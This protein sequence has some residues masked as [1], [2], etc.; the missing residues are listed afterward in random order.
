MTI[1][2]NR[3]LIILL[4]SNVFISAYSQKIVFDKVDANGER[5]VETSMKS[6]SHWTSTFSIK[7]GMEAKEKQGETKYRL[8]AEFKCKDKIRID[9]YMRMLIKTNSGTVMEIKCSQEGRDATGEVYDPVSMLREYTVKVYYDISDEQIANIKNEGLA[10]VRAEMYDRD[11]NEKYTENRNAGV[12]IIRAY[13]ALN[14]RIDK[15]RSF[16]DGF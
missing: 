11:I 1:M 5:R 10:K 3:Y 12:Y 15:R 14:K 7:Y 16:T 4:L 8:I 6:F 9:T 2:M 13:N